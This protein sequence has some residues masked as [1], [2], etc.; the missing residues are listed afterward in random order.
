MLRQRRAFRGHERGLQRR[1]LYWHWIVEDDHYAVTGAAL[2]RKDVPE[3]A[4]WACVGEPPGDQPAEHRGKA[5]A[6]ST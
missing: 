2:D 4:P 3:S 6:D 5:K 1:V